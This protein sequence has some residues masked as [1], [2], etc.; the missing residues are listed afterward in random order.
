MH[1]LVISVLASVLLGF[2]QA[3]NSVDEAS[4][5]TFFEN[6]YQLL[7]REDGNGMVRMWSA[8]T[9]N[10]GAAFT[11][12]RRDNWAHITNT[13]ESANL[14]ALGSRRRVAGSHAPARRQRSQV[15]TLR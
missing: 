5:R 3:Q 7:S 2:S 14:G 15:C 6:Y 10:L 4:L 11:N 1:T 9:P 8:T 12:S 13:S